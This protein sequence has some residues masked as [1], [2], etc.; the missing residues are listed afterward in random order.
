M[1]SPSPRM[2]AVALYLLGALASG[3][4][5]MYNDISSFYKEIFAM[6]M[7]GLTLSFIRDELDATL[8]GDA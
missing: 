6:P 2:T 3:A 7:D 4:Y 5:L 1:R 8:T